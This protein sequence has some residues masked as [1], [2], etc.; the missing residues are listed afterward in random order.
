MGNELKFKE[1]FEIFADVFDRKTPAY[2]SD[3]NLSPSAVNKWAQMPFTE[4]EF[5]S[6]GTRNPLDRLLMIIKKAETLNP[7]MALLPIEWL[8]ACLGLMPP[9]RMPKLDCSDEETL[10]AVLKR[11]EEYGEASKAI[12][13]ALSK[14]SPG[15]GKITRK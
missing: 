11:D 1:S 5:L 15:G 13:K 12:C 7:D 4:E 10:I 8:C 9:V 6:S 2:A 3:L 14:E